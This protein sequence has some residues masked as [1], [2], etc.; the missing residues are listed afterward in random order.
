MIITKRLSAPSVWNANQSW[1]YKALWTSGDYRLQVN[2]RRNAFEDQSYARV[3]VWSAAELKWSTVVSQPITL[4]VCKKVSYVQENVT[5]RNFA[6]DEESLLDEA[7]I[8]LHGPAEADAD[9]M[10]S[11]RAGIILKKVQKDCEGLHFEVWEDDDCVGYG[12][13]WDEDGIGYTGGTPSVFEDEE[14]STI[15]EDIAFAWA[16]V[17]GM[18]VKRPK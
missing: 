18:D 9:L 14:I 5:I 4:M 17:M 13:L 12:D 16:E 15:V 7:A 1:Y 3:E 10:H 8:V 6:A 2:I 11:G